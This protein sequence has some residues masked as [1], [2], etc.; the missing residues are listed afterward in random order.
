MTAPIEQTL[1]P[2]PGATAPVR[3][4]PQRLWPW[5]VLITLGVAWGLS[6]ALMRVAA[7]SGRD[8]IG[9]LAWHHG[10][11]SLMVL[12]PSLLRRG[13]Y[14]GG[15]H[16]LAICVTGGLLSAL[17]PS[18]IYYFAASHVPSG[19][20]SIT[21][22]VAPIMT[23][24]LAVLLGIE[25]FSVLR[26]LGVAL[27]A[28]AIALLVVPQT[29][30]PDPAQVPWVL[31]ACLAAVCYSVQNLI[32][33]RWTPRGADP[34]VMT[35]GM[36]GTSAVILWIYLAATG[37]ILPLDWPPGKIELAIAGLAAISAFAYALLVYLIGHSG[38]VFGS[39]CA[40]VITVAGVGW[41]IL[42]FG[43]SH[44]A[45]IWSS[46]VV[47]LLGLSLVQPRHST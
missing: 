10:L 46:L 6:F 34:V 22:T 9:I 8:P 1:A 20:L 24:L 17:V 27:G 4:L 16:L 7:E 15:W 40:Y 26:M 12:V 38:A 23:F 31:A 36:F 11:A 32:L 2:M 30:L 25:A 3:S 19:V 47:M 39:Q 18:V 28:L 29:S 43:E 13:A 33:S 14:A 21:I 37:T 41:G 44:S 42:L 5:A 45:W 35:G